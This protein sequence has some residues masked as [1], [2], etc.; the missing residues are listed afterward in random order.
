[1]AKMKLLSFILLMIYFTS[2][3]QAFSVTAISKEITV[4]LGDKF[5]LMCKSSGYYEVSVGLLFSLLTLYLFYSLKLHSI[6]IDIF[7]VVHLH[8]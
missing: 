5:N 2:S 6:N 4:N 8:T 1:M 7:S 3:S